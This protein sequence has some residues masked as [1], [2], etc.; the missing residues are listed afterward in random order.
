MS[1]SLKLRNASAGAIFLAM[2]A[3]GFLIFGTGKGQTT[4]DSYVQDLPPVTG[5]DV[6][7]GG[8]LVTLDADESARRADVIAEVTV[9]KP[10]APFWNTADKA[11]PA[12]NASEVLAT[13]SRIFTPVQLQVVNTL[14]GN[15][16]PGQVLTVNRYGGR[17]GEDRF[18]IEEPYFVEGDRLIVFLRDCSTER[19]TLRVQQGFGY[20]FI[21]RFEVDSNGVATKILNRDPVQLT[22]LLNT[23]ESE[24]DNAPLSPTS[25]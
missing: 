22:E 10:G 2:L 18:L 13:A 15:A 25:C 7:S 17:V 9:L 4:T 6:S 5:I 23:I 1:T 8:Y 16:Q 3:V 20:R 21:Q 24:K 19:S 11:R 14:K 12:G